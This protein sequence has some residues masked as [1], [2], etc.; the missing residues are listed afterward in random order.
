MSVLSV[1][2]LED[3]DISPVT[4]FLPPTPPLKRLPN[5]YYEPWEEIVD[6]LSGLLKAERLRERVHKVGTS[7]VDSD[8][9]ISESCVRDLT[10]I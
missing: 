9:I 7:A 1:S 5:A 2:R 10:S 3:Y 8:L 6:D 4:G